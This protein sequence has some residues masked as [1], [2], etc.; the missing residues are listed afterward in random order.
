MM[1]RK[2]IVSQQTKDTCFDDGTF[3]HYFCR[4]GCPPLDEHSFYLSDLQGY[5][6]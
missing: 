6:A 5:A 4:N 3:G 1:R 2:N